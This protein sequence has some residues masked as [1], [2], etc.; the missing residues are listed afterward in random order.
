MQRLTFVFVWTA[1][2]C[3]AQ[4]RKSPPPAGWPVWGG[5]GRDFVTTSTG[6]L[7]G[8]ASGWISTPPRT[9]WKRPLGDGYSAIAEENGVLYTAYRRGSN[10]VVI[11]LDALTGKTIWEH[12]YPAPFRNA[13]AEAAPGPYAMP[14][15]IGARVVAASG[16]GQIHSRTRRPASGPGPTTSIRSLEASVSTSGILPT[17]FLI[18]TP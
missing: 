11:A 6:I 5:P 9:L 14:Q 15:V 4:T 12:E 17:P 3:A 2:L 7:G 1:F 18:R 10:D 8:P 16:V 13:F